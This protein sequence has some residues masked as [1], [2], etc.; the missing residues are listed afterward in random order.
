MECR[1]FCLPNRI[2]TAEGSTLIKIMRYCDIFLG[3]ALILCYP[4]GIATKKTVLSFTCC[5]MMVYC[6]YV[7]IPII[8]NSIFSALLIFFETGLGKW[9][10]FIRKYFGFMYSYTGR[11]VFT[12]LLYLIPFIHI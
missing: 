11:T 4:I 7:F 5:F 8:R 2:S 9:E 6:M 1:L 10:G 3:V 12:L